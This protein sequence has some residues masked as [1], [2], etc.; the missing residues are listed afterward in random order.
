MDK[1]ALVIRTGAYGDMLIIS[2]LFKAL[3]GK[4]YHVILHTG[5]RG[6]DVLKNNPYIDEIIPY[7]L[8]GKENPQIEKEWEELEK[9]INPDW[10][11]NY[12]ESIEVNIS[13]HPKS[14]IY[15][16]PKQER[17]KRGNRNFYEVTEELSQRDFGRNSIKFDEYRPQLFFDKEEIETVTQYIEDDKFNILWALSGSGGQK[18]YPWTDYVMGEILKNYDNVHFI[19]VGDERCQIL[20]DM[21]DDKN[22]TNL[23]GEISFRQS[24]ILTSLVDLVIS[25]DTGVLHAAGAFITPKIGLLGHTTIENITKHFIN[26]YSI[27]ADEKLAPCSPCFRLIY[28]HKIQCPLDKLTLGAWCMSKGIEKEVLYKRIEEV[29]EKHGNRKA[30]KSTSIQKGMSN[31]QQTECASKKRS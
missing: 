28:N 19:T 10:F 12:A 17:Y 26:D 2:P 11:G 23:S 24:M 9:K 18:V 20:E 22:I 21:I 13:L 14:P 31:M 5:Q 4:G 25:P 7:E 30:K 8:E 15:N 27:Q 29:I 16:Y 1:K 6:I 3:K